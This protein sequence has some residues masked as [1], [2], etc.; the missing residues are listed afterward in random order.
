MFLVV[1]V[2][3]FLIKWIVILMFLVCLF[4]AV[5][6][7]ELVMVVHVEPTTILVEAAHQ[8][9]FPCPKVRRRRS[10]WRVNCIAS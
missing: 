7:R 9:Q 1:E 3:V 10:E 8:P 6:S 5:N 4:V 2:Y